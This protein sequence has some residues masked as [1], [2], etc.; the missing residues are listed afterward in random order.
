[1]VGAG[2]LALTGLRED[3]EVDDGLN[4]WRRLCIKYYI[5]EFRAAIRA[6]NKWE[7][8]DRE[9]T[10]EERRA[11]LKRIERAQKDL[12][13]LG[14]LAELKF[15]ASNQPPNVVALKVAKRHR[16]T[17]EKQNTEFCDIWTS[18]TNVVVIVCRPEYVPI[19]EGFVREADVP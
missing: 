1:M 18:G 3:G 4:V 17:F 7:P 10:V 9:W 2:V 6:N 11:S 5:R 15:V 16:A 12:V 13:G 14:Y 8:G 19:Y